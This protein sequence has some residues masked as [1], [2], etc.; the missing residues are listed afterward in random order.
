MKII[1]SPAKKIKKEAE[2]IFEPRI[3]VFL[4]EAKQLAQSIKAISFADLKTLLACNDDIAY[5]N[6]E[7][8][9][10]MDFEKNLYHALLAYDGIQYKYMSPLI[11]DDDCFEYVSKHLRIVSA[12]YGLLHPLDGIQAY[13]LEMQAKLQ[14]SF[15]KDLYDFWGKKLADELL[16]DENLIINLASKEYSKGIEKYLPDSAQFVTCSFAE[17]DKKNGKLVEKGV[18]VKMARGE[19]VRYMAENK[20]TDVEGLKAFTGLGFSYNQAISDR[21]LLVFVR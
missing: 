19:M 12:L 2:L 16:K 1:I 11:F 8:Y 13:R 5:L 7:R 20:V 14:T 18:Y 17:E 9:K 10:Y 21:N 15:C 6:Y 3:P 4:E